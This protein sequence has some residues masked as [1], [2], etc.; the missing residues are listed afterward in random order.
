MTLETTTKTLEQILIW[1][2]GVYAVL[3]GFILFKIRRSGYDPVSEYAKSRITLA[4][5][6]RFLT[7]LGKRYSEI[8]ESNTIKTAYETALWVGVIGF[9]VNFVLVVVSAVQH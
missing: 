8:F 5:D 3:L 4:V 6:V 1:D 7:Q 2:I 9:C